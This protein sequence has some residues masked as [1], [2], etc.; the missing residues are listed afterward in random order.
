MKFKF[1]VSGE[2]RGGSPFSKFIESSERVLDF[3]F[4]K[5][6]G[7]G[8]INIFSLKNFPPP[9]IQS[10]YQSGILIDTVYDR[11]I[12]VYIYSVLV[13]TLGKTLTKN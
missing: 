5:I 12:T 11:G 10:N 8:V 3:K 6:V 1:V 4:N 9:P 2:Y 7:R 13:Y